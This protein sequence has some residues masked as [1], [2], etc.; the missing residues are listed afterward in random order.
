MA[1]G[2]LSGPPRAS[3]I[4]LHIHPYSANCLPGQLMIQ[5]GLTLWGSHFLGSMFSAESLITLLSS[6]SP[7]TT[8]P[9]WILFSFCSEQFQE[10]LL[11]VG[12]FTLFNPK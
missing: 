10:V 8:S 9:A 3:I 7:D 1:S 6:T 5:L 11:S 12:D 4:F 2:W